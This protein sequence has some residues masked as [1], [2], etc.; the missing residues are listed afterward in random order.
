MLRPD[1]LFNAACSSAT[2][3]ST[4]PTHPCGSYLEAPR[5]RGAESRSSEPTA[6]YRMQRTFLP[7]SASTSWGWTFLHA[8]VA[9][10][11]LGWN[12]HPS[13]RFPMEGTI[14]GITYSLR[15]SRLI[16]GTDL[17]SPTVY[18]CKGEW[19]ISL[20]EP[21]SLGSGGDRR[22]K[23]IRRAPLRAG[24]RSSTPSWCLFHTTQC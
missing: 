24:C 18:R 1:L 13:G 17:R 3:R 20:T 8:S 5:S 15:F 4:S 21:P 7:G 10:S 23:S 11:H 16:R 2:L 22:P 14:P 9:R 19:K 6:P 12:L